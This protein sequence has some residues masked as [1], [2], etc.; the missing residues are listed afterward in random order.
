MLTSEDW[1]IV[2]VAAG[3]AGILLLASPTLAL[4][5]QLPQG[6]RFSELWLLGPGMMTQDYPFNVTANT[7]YSVNVGVGNHMGSSVYYDLYVKFRNESETAP[8]DTAETPSPLPTLYARRAFVQDGENWT[9]PLDFSFSGIS[10]AGSQSMI[11]NVTINGMS[12]NVDKTSSWDSENRGYYY[13]LFVELWI[14]NATSDSIQFHDRFV[15]LW[16]NATL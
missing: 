8:N 11:H 5:V 6:E 3:L 1:K 7:N 14:Y 16:L 4:I 10:F 15:G 12:V 9:D 2:F 13:Q